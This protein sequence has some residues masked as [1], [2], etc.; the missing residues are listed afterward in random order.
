MIGLQLS[1]CSLACCDYIGLTFVCA[2]HN[3]AA[4]LAVCAAMIWV[5]FHLPFLP[6]SCLWLALGTRSFVL[7]AAAKLWSCAIQHQ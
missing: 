4:L 2:W 6:G 7:M 5:E 1:S 3:L